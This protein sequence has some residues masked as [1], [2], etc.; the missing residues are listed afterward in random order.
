VA[1][2]ERAAAAVDGLIG[3]LGLVRPGD[4]VIDLGCGCGAMVPSLARRVGPA[5]SYLGVDVHGPSVRWCR[6]RWGGEAGLRF[7][8]APVR[9]PYGAR[10]G[11]EAAAYRL[12]AA[13]GEAGFVLAKSLFTHLLEDDA[14]AY[15]REVARVL[16]PGRAALVTAFLFDG[17]RFRTA[18]PPAFPHPGPGAPVRFRRRVRPQAAVAYEVG[19]FE[20]MVAATGLAVGR[21]IDGFYPG[22]DRRPQGQDVVVLTARPEGAAPPSGAPGAAG[23]TPS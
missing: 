16:A 3:D 6:R 2:F 8:V 13:D 11:V 15:L 12:P 4:R 5:G 22:E 19:H 20:G 21:R 7:E 14:L 9:S 17:G 10:G 1:E 18:P 23:R